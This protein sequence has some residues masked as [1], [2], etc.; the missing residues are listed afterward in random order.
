MGHIDNNFFSESEN[1]AL[2]RDIVGPKPNHMLHVAADATTNHVKRALM[3]KA[4]ASIVIISSLIKF[5]LAIQAS[6]NAN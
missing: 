3:C 4:N 5:L 2:T 1:S 6:S